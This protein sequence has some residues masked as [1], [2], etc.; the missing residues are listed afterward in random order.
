LATAAL[1]ESS[2]ALQLRTELIDDAV[3]REHRLDEVR[4]KRMTAEEELVAAKRAAASR[5]LLEAE[6]AL[7]ARDQAAGIVSAISLSQ[8]DVERLKRQQTG[9]SMRKRAC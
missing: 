4:K 9:S 3:R 6:A 7:L 5:R 8:A 1:R 2:R